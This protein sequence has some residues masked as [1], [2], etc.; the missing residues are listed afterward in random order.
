MKY[1]VNILFATKHFT[2][3]TSHFTLH[4]SKKMGII[5][6]Q[7]LKASV[8]VYLGVIIGMVN[9]LLVSTYYLSKEQ[10]AL[11]RILIENSLVFAAFS[12]LGIGAIIDRYFVRFKDDE[13]KHNGFL[14]FALIYPLFGL[15][16]FGILYVV[17]KGQ[18][19]AYFA[20][21]ASLLNHYHLLS[22]PLTFVWTYLLV[23]EVYC[24]NHSRIAIPM[25]LREV[26]LKIFNITLILMFAF[27]WISFDWLMYG[28]VVIHALVLVASV[29]YVKRLKKLYFTLNWSIFRGDFFKQMFVYGVIVM[30]GV[31]GYGVLKFID[32]VMLANEKGLADAGIF[33]LA[34]MIAGIIEIPKKTIAQISAPIMAK[35]IHQQEYDKAQELTQNG[36]INQFWAG[37]LVWLGLF[38]CTD[39]I[40]MFLP[41]GNEYASGKYVILFIG[42]SHVL[43]MSVGFMSEI[44]SYSKYYFVTTILLF[45]CAGMVI[46]GNNYAI[47]LYGVNGAATVTGTVVIFFALA[48][49]I[50]VWK[51]YKIFSFTKNHFK[52]LFINALII[53]LICIFP[54]TSHN[55]WVAFGIIIVKTLGILSIFFFLLIKMNISEDFNKLFKTGIQLVKDKIRF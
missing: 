25:F 10:L 39:E 35:Y 24:K 26:L 51:I 18:I 23:L 47:P 2:F 5:I 15:F 27:N 46:L 33:I 3:H 29:L 40:F 20:E 42:I 21:N 50:A 17:F 36:A 22:L 4:T 37:S 32:R 41:K 34:V 8:A 30:S 49:V 13:K 54:K 28:M 45:I 6:R 7:S 52:M 14:V 38:A 44:I 43:D 1:E 31:L 9:V 55:L 19:V 11:I 53:G 48:R 16:V 12:Q